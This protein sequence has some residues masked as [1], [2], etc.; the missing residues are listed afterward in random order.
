MPECNFDCLGNSTTSFP[1]SE[2]IYDELC[3]NECKIEYEKTWGKDGEV[4]VHC[5]NIP[6]DKFY[7][8]PNKSRGN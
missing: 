2:S 8:I 7:T 3:C 5:G 4:T 6:P 1:M